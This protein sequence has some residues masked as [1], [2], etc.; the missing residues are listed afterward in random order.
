M[1]SHRARH[2]ADQNNSEELA[3]DLLARLADEVRAPSS[4]RTRRAAERPAL[5]PFST[6]PFPAR[7]PR[8]PEDT[9]DPG[10]AGPD[11]AG[12]DPAVSNPAGPP[13]MP[14]G[15][16]AVPQ[17]RG[18][19]QPHPT[20]PGGAHP[21]GTRPSTA[22]RGQGGNATASDGTQ[23]GS[24]ALPQ[25]RGGATRRTAGGPEAAGASDS[26]PMAPE[27]PDQRALSLRSGPAAELSAGY[28]YAPESGAH[29]P[30]PRFPSDPTAPFPLE[31]TPAG[32]MDA[33]RS[34]RERLAA[35][36]RKPIYAAVSA[37]MITAA[38]AATTG[39]AVVTPPQPSPDRSPSLAAAALDLAPPAPQPG[40]A[41]AVP[42]PGG[43]AVLTPNTPATSDAA[44]VLGSTIAAQAAADAKA[45]AQAQA[46]QAAGRPA[47]APRNAPAPKAAPK[48]A[49]KQAPKPAAAP[50]TGS[51][52]G[53][54]ALALAKGKL[55]APYVWGAA[56]PSA[57]D[58]S[59]LIVWAYKQLG[60][61]LPHSS[62]TL[63]TM[64]T[65][66]SKAALQPGDLV[67]FYSPVSHVGIYAGNGM[68]LNA[69]QS[70][71]PVQFSKLANLPFHNAVRLAK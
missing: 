65:P 70:G 12:P 15:S 9:A 55:G 27:A 32:L 11:P 54:R 19:A 53:A 66:V 56:G 64:G 50:A 5:D 21:D 29:V 18:G 30:A 31:D 68:V 69:T 28:G 51:S 41:A 48:P 63:S 22:A 20:Q 2:R 33:P 58:C 60:V 42:V 36:G 39:P 47:T 7:T 52:V 35:L 43:P 40:A 67:F 4:P 3:T 6:A 38:V 57:F 8:A 26:G 1:G 24:A 71:E 37:T 17:Q 13:T 23:P 44:P 59:G 61:S 10:V 62:A 25:Q 34:G 46:R 14:P 16:A 49:V 45:Y